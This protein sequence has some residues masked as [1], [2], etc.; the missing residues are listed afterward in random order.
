LLYVTLKVQQQ[1]FQTGELVWLFSLIHMAMVALTQFIVVP[2]PTYAWHTIEKPVLEFVGAWLKA[3]GQL[4]DHHF[5]DGSIVPNFF[6]FDNLGG[7]HVLHYSNT[8]P[9]SNIP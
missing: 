6:G 4:P 9:A 3:S 7:F 5:N 2:H 1:T 8:L